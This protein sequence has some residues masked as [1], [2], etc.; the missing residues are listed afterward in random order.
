[1]STGYS[2]KKN[3]VFDAYDLQ[4]QLKAKLP[5]FIEDGRK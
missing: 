1:M 5:K 4:K 3:E 2:F